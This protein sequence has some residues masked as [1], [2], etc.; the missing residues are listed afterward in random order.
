MAKI[1]E[2]FVK[3]IDRRINGVIKADSQE[4]K[5]FK[6]EID[7]YVITSELTGRF[8]ELLDRYIGSLSTQTEDVGVW[9][10][11][12]FGS[13]KSHLL[14]MLGIL[15][16]NKTIE[17]KLPLEYFKEKTTDAKLI[18]SFEALKNTDTLS[19]LFNIDAVGNKNIK[20]EK[21]NIAPVLLKEFYGKLGFTKKFIKIATFERELWLEDK[22]EEFK[23]KFNAYY[24]DKTWEE[25]RDL[26]TLKYD[27]FVKV[28]SE[29]GYLTEDEAMTLAK[30][31]N[32]SLSIEE[33]ADIIKK[34]INKKGN[35]F[36]VVFLLDEIGQYIRDNEELMLNLQTV[37]EK[38]GTVCKGRVWLLVTAQETMDNMITEN[39]IKRMEFSKIQGRFK[40][41][42]SLTSQNVDE[43]IQKRL[44]SKKELHKSYL[45]NYYGD[46]GIRI[47][48]G[49]HFSEGTKSLEKFR[50]SNKFSEFYPLVP[51]QFELL[52]QVFEN[53]R[54]QG[55]TGKHMSEGERSMLT[56]IQ[57]AV[58]SVMDQEI[59]VMIPFNSFYKP[60]ENF[61]NPDIARTI[62]KASS[63]IN[64]ESYDVEILKVLFMVKDIAG[65]SLNME[66][67][68][69]L[70]LN[71][72]DQDKIELEKKVKDGL[73][74]LCKQHLVTEN[75]GVYKFLTDEEQTINRY[76]DEES[77]TPSQVNQKVIDKIFKRIFVSNQIKSK[78]L[79]NTFNFNKKF[80]D[81]FTGGQ[82]ED[83][84]LAI[85]SENNSINHNEARLT[86][87]SSQEKTLFIKL[88][89]CRFLEEIEKIIKIN[90]YADKVPFADLDIE[91]RRIIEGKREEARE[92]EKNIETSI[93]I[94]IANGDFFVA[95]EK[96]SISKSNAK[97]K[98][99]DALEILV[100][101]VYS[102][103]SY[104]T[105]HYD[106]KSLKELFMDENVLFAANIYS[107]HS[108]YLAFNELKH[109]IDSFKRVSLKEV[110]DRYKA[111][112]YGFSDEDIAGLLS[113]MVLCGDLR[114]L[115]SEAKVEKENILKTLRGQRDRAITIIEKNKK[116]DEVLLTKV[117][118]IA[119]DFFGELIV[120]VTEEEIVTFIK[121]K[122]QNEVNKVN[123]TLYKFNLDA[124]FIYPGY[125]ASIDYKN[126]L[127]KIIDI[128][129]NE[130]FFEN[131]SK[132]SEN[133]FDLK[134][135]FEHFNEF[136]NREYDKVFDLGI[137]TLKKAKNY[138]AL[139]I[140]LEG[141]SD[142]QKIKDI[143]NSNEPVRG[144][145]E[146]NLLTSKIEEKIKL[147]IDKWKN[148]IKEDIENKLEV[149][150]GT[151]GNYDS[152]ILVKNE[153]E[154]LTNEL[155]QINEEGLR[156]YSNKIKNAEKNV[157]EI[158]K[159]TLN[160]KLSEAEKNISAK[161]Q[162]KDIGSSIKAKL[163]ESYTNV[164][165]RVKTINNY[166]DYDVILSLIND[167]E[168]NGGY[169]LDGVEY[170]K[171]EIILNPKL[172]YKEFENIEDVDSYVEE[173]R[174]KLRNEILSGKK[175]ILG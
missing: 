99:S 59:D 88:N 43:V 76:I 116:V 158:L 118:R 36:R 89:D 173:L 91:K 139:D 15:L 147:I 114:V 108:N 128:K 33:F 63:N 32:D 141:D 55:Y 93:E 25:Y 152:V 10:S 161:G 95:G 42:L 150:I 5:E 27:A 26:M 134:E 126:D 72:L 67:I 44:L 133:L 106:E 28:A 171:P 151:L 86:T 4:E 137:K 149:A 120:A 105:K 13:G 20:Q 164:S 109:F 153:F 52:Q 12:F 96:L 115:L 51:Y 166:S 50:T 90:Q 16:G 100:N 123:K 167:Y 34:C 129:E 135:R 175:V 62:G 68:I 102:K 1:R 103:N 170:K 138:F 81:Q 45:E 80:D 57:D 39:T 66:N 71:K 156:Y 69:T 165:N 157:L 30:N 94:A 124:E 83:L 46:N 3:E 84:T 172:S 136:F 37:S 140:S 163:N 58:V 64:I 19:I 159:K 98:I 18:K 29:N 169:I 11:G 154:K 8:N 122:L 143:L 40:T 144:I 79:N 148:E 119:K 104:V 87:L 60:I 65:V 121:S 6:E 142:L 112:P 74:R 132:Q 111:V 35:K 130:T 14:K 85:V 17:G 48:N 61:I 162:G 78:V 127:T 9:I 54:K 155:P 23:E 56:S 77:V 117:K 125:K 107:G 7:E 145:N 38:L 49:I 75:N 160:E 92:R 2:L 24:P 113:E 22:Y 31:P 73:N 101:K 53:I 21:N 41:K 47:D 97:D 82:S 168:V 131:F 174:K 146:I 70:M 110:Y